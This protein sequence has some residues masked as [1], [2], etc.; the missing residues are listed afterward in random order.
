[1]GQSGC[2]NGEADSDI[3]TTRVC[4][5]WLCGDKWAINLC[6][7]VRI[8][9]TVCKLDPV[10]LS[11]MMCHSRTVT[12]YS[13]FQYSI[14]L[15]RAYYLQY[16][17]WYWSLTNKMSLFLSLYLFSKCFGPSYSIIRSSTSC[18]MLV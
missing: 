11:H 3:L 15:I 16:K 18:G 9:V 12:L 10:E 4:V 8:N 7:M 14:R 17:Y 5:H 1:V 6:L 13:F 2:N